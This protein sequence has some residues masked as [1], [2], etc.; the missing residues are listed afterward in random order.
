MTKQFGFLPLD[1]FIRTPP[2]SVSRRL[3]STIELD[4]AS[5]PP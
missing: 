4:G 2:A 3:S 1:E 5:S